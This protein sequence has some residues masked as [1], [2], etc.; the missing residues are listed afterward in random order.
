MKRPL[1]STWAKVFVYSVLAVIAAAG[2]IEAQ[3][4]Q[5]P[6]KPARP[7]SYDASKE[8]TINGTVTSVLT[9]PSTG[10]IMGGHVILQTSSGSLDASLGTLALEGKDAPPLA[11]GQAVVVTGV[12]KTLNGQ[13]VL[14]TRTLKI[15]DDVY[16]IRN[17]HGFP[18]S[19]GTSVRTS[20]PAAQKGEQP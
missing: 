14:L 4:A 12:L 7:F 9:K 10:M 16:S 15:G 5:E 20:A 3:S 6:T 11:A 1:N 18:L 17:E 13:Q 8:V 2:T 19:S